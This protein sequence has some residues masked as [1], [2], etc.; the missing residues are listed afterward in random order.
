MFQDDHVLECL[1]LNETE[2]VVS[3]AVRSGGCMLLIR[4]GGK[5]SDEAAVNLQFRLQ[6]AHE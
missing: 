4:A 6:F 1:W 5:V 3:A 2:R